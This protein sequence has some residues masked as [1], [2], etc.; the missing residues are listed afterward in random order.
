VKVIV[1]MAD[2]K[3]ASTHD[4]RR[5]FGTRWSSKVMP[6]VLMQLMRHDSIETTM[7]FMWGRT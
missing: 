4:L 6:A 3:F 5:S 7:K 2:G 1:N